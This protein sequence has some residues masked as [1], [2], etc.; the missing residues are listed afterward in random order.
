MAH[1]RLCAAPAPHSNEQIYAARAEVWS[2]LGD[3]LHRSTPR[4]WKGKA[5]SVSM[6]IW[7]CHIWITQFAAPIA[8][9]RPIAHRIAEGQRRDRV[10]QCSVDVE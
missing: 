6:R 1:G 10:W 8:L 3:G 9:H 4:E 5:E 2:P 7:Y